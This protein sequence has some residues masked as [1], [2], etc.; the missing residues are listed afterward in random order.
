MLLSGQADFWGLIF[1]HSQLATSRTSRLLGADFMQVNLLLPGQADLFGGVGRFLGTV[2]LQLPG[3]GLSTD[4][5][6]NKGLPQIAISGYQKVLFNAHLCVCGNP[7][8]CKHSISQLISCSPHRT[9]RPLSVNTYLKRFIYRSLYTIVG[10]PNQLLLGIFSFK[11]GCLTTSIRAN[12]N[13]KM[14]D[15]SGLSEAN[16]LI[17]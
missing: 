9:F 15:S 6:E 3:R 10:Q 13:L 7:D 4:T 11:G 5:S 14:A 16:M 1:R 12:N 17:F 8:R 2:K